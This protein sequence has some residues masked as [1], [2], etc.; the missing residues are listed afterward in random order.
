MTTLTTPMQATTGVERLILVAA[1]AAR[2]AVARRVRRRTD[3]IGRHSAAVLVAA[4]ER[5]H[6]AVA[7]GAVGI[8][9][10]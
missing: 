3:V 7:R 9:P 8:F 10:G 2:G 1:D 5:R 6:L 4:A